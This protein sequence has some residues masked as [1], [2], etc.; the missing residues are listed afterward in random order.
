MGNQVNSRTIRDRLWSIFLLG[1]TSSIVIDHVDSLKILSHEADVFADR[2]QIGEHREEI[3][4]HRDNKG[5]RLNI[6][7]SVENVWDCANNSRCFAYR[8]HMYIGTYRDTPED[9]GPHR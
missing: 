5:K 3:R 9:I 2:C 1:I 6:G 4:T 7:E 8:D